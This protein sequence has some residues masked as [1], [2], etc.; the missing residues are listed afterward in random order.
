MCL[1]HRSGG[2]RIL[3][4]VIDQ[5]FSDAA[6]LIETLEQAS[7]Q[8]DAAALAHAAHLLSLGSQFVGALRLGQMCVEL[9]RASHAAETHGLDQQIVRIR[10]EYEAVHLAME[11]VRSGG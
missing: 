10:Q 1:N 2:P 7:E 3:A 5:Y 9:E 6:R 11:E 8:L 4:G